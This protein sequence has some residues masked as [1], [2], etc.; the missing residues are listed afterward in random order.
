[1]KL[2]ILILF[3]LSNLIT[4][5]CLSQTTG[6]ITGKISDM[7]SAEVLIGVNIMLLGTNLGT[8][9]DINGEFYLLNLPPGSYNLSVSM[10]GYKNTMVEDVQVSVNR[11]TPLTLQMTPSVLEGDVVVVKADQVSIKKDQTSSV[12]N[13]SS[14]QIDIM[15][16]E[17]IGQII[18]MQTG[19]VAGH[20]RGGRSTEVTYLVDGIKVDEIYGGSSSTIELEIGSVSELEIITGTFNA[21]YGKAMSG[22][23][24]QVTKSGG[25]EFKT[26]LQ[27]GY[28]NY[29][30]SNVEIFPGI[31]QLDE[32]RYL[33]YRFQL[34]GPIIK[35]KVNFFVNYRLEDNYNHLNGMH[36]FNPTDKSDYLSDS[37]SSWLSEHTGGH[38]MESYC[39]SS[40]GVAILDEDNNYIYDE[41]VCIN[42]Y[43]ECQI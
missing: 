42:E 30:T 40:K 7:E 41:S 37:S 14:D 27:T 8:A 29:I 5:V 36:Y 38:E 6:K 19:I 21:E 2:R 17:N 43:G 31:D 11:T 15:P 9:S 3:V 35:G 34:S 39:M 20:F 16:V 12:K 28:A 25:D 26:S 4:T 1:M 13:I 10:I 24:N 18:G 23:V 22:V 32:N 33:D